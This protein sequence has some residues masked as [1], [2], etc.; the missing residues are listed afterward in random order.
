M[1]ILTST[2]VGQHSTARLNIILASSSFS[3]S[4][5]CFQSLTEFGISSSAAINNIQSI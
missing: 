4:T 1:R 3:N 5:A 2:L